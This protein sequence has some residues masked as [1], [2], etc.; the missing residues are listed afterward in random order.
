[1]KGFFKRFILENWSLKAT[2]L[3][4]ALILWALV[5]GEP[6]QERGLPVPLEVLVPRNMEITN[7]L[8][9]SAAITYRGPTLASIGTVT[10]VIDLRNAK[11]GGH[12]VSLTSDNV[13]MTSG[14]GIEILQVNPA[15]VRVVLEKTVSREVPIVASIEGDPS[16]GFEIYSTSLFPETVI[17]SGPRSR[18]EPVQKVDTDIISIEGKNQLTRSF[19]NLAL[20]DNTIRTS[21][22]GP[23][24]VTVRIGPFRKLHTIE[25][26]PVVVDGD[27]YVV[28]PVEISIRVLAPPELIPS[29]TP[30]DFVVTVETEN[31]ESSNFPPTI[32]PSIHLLGGMDDI[33]DIV[34]I[35]PAEVAIQPKNRSDQQ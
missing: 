9:T 33:V 26:V 17:L 25:Q 34:E 19:V 23:V 7:D 20:Q 8:P 22:I 2:A 10:C 31:L 29:L 15:R 5:R 12:T 30:A 6:G 13:R 3:L 4:L 27:S 32:K 28:E 1:M 14:L 11:E 21:V 18:I 16:E 24:Q 35:S